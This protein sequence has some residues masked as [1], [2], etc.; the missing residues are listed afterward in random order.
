MYRNSVRPSNPRLPSRDKSVRSTTATV[1]WNARNRRCNKEAGRPI[2]R[3]MDLGC[4]QSN[5]GAGDRHAA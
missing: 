1:H 5:E 3:E 2:R 4:P